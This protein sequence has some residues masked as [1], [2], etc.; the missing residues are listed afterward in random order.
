MGNIESVYTEYN[1]V[2]YDTDR[3]YSYYDLLSLLFN[4]CRLI[5]RI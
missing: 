3:K 2:I 1:D 5:P 4:A